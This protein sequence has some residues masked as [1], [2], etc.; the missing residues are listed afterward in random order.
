MAHRN[1]PTP[2]EQAVEAIASLLPHDADGPPPGQQL[3][4]L[5][6]LEK[7]LALESGVVVGFTQPAG[8]TGARVL[9]FDPE[10][11]ALAGV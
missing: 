5:A 10:L 3:A 1:G 4:P 6:I 11:S 8:F 2:I 7:G 9:I